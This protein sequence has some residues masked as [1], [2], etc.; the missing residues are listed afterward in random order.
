MGSAEDEDIS[1][2]VIGAGSGGRLIA[3]GLRKPYSA[4]LTLSLKAGIPCT[5]FEQ[6]ASLDARTHDWDFGIYWAQTPLG[7]C[8][9]PDVRARIVAAQVDNVAPSADAHLATFNAETGELMRRVP[10][11]YYLRL[12]RREFA[13][14]MGGG[15]DIR[16][17][18][19]LVSVDAT[20]GDGVT[21]IFGDGTRHTA[22][23][24]VGAEG[25]H[26]P[27]REYLVGPEKGALL[28]SGVVLSIVQS[29][30]PVGKALELCR[31]HPRNALTFHPNGTFMWFGVH[32]AY[33]KPDPAE[34]EFTFMTSWKQTGPVTFADS[35]EIIRDMKQRAAVFAEPFRS[36]ADAIDEERKA[37]S[38]Y[39]PYWPTQGW[40]GHPARGKV[41]LAGDAAHP[42]TP[43][44]GQ[45]LNNAILDCHQFVQ[46]VEAMP[47][48]TPEALSEAV[49]RYEMEMWE[50]GHEAVMS[51][52][53]NSLAVHDWDV[54]MQS[55]F[56][57]DG[58]TQ[59]AARMGNGRGEKDAQ[60]SPTKV[61]PEGLSA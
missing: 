23:V 2:M 24:L 15:I 13:R 50:R 5:V 52:L 10:A 30:L 14:V 29:K 53:E 42:M 41:T 33:D 12:R 47:G 28:N 7:A 35:K 1:V 26:S 31:L 39:L 51:S 59:T 19:R 25:A 38:N 22:T 3:Q 40:E 54:L 8:L 44:R 61:R 32:D 37:Y 46:Q 4:N 27:V 57:K 18:K 56:F 55:P 16:Y 60:Q 17:G 34:W 49:V 36:I 6:D 58:L 48:R 45:G 11:P 9:P 21:A 20:S 43:H